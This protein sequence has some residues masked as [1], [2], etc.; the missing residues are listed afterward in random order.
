MNIDWN[1]SEYAKKCAFV[2][3]HGKGLV[4]LLTVAKGSRVLDLGCGRGELTAYLR[5]LGWD[6]EGMDASASQLADARAAYPEIKFFDGDITSFRVGKPYAA[7]FSNAVLHWIDEEDQPAALAGIRAALEDG[8]EFVFEMGG[9]GNGDVIHTA[10]RE[11]IMRRRAPYSHRFFFP[12]A[13]Q[14]SALLE[15]VGF[16]VEFA[17][18]FD[19]PTPL[20][21]ENG[22]ADWICIFAKNELA[23]LPEEERRDAALAAQEKCRDKLFRD[24][25]WVADY[26][27]LRMKAIAGL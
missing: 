6:A 22:V 10:L 16:K 1:T 23:G 18:L 9:K 12:D 21:G 4:G 13:E 8:G 26:V 15:R 2:G 27:R 14:Y 24:G 5:S 20:S 3:E 19:R 11:E 17:S 25:V 7:V